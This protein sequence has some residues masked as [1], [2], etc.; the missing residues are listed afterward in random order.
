M[1]V[2][3]YACQECH[4]EFEKVLSVD[5]HEHKEIVCPKCGSKHVEQLVTPFFA[6]TSKKS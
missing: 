3:D 4:A 1:P 5:E 2:Y 6:V